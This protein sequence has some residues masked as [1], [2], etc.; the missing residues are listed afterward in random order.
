MV[1][2]NLRTI[3]V[4]VVLKLVGWVDAHVT[5]QNYLPKKPILQDF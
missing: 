3:K 1:M 4:K 2:L 5:Q